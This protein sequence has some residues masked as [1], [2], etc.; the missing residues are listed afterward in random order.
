MKK[1]MAIGMFLNP[2]T[3][4]Q[5]Q[6]YMP[7][8]VPATLQLYLDGKME[9]FWLI[10]GTVG[11]IFLMS[12]E[13]VDEAKSLLDALPLTRDGLMEFDLKPVGPLTPLQS[14]MK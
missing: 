2:V 9:Q 1:V 7:M 13:S 4:E 11:V 5:M 8:E 6:K 14:L 3:P 10:E 12:V